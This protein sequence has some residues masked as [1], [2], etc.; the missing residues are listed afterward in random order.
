MPAG[1]PAPPGHSTLR[2]RLLIGGLVLAAPVVAAEPDRTQAAA[3][4]PPAFVRRMLPDAALAGEGRLRFFGLR[5]YDARLWV[6]RRFDADDFGA[7]PLALEL[8]Y[9]RSFAGVDIAKRSIEE[10]E[11]QGGLMPGQALR[12][13]KELAGV[14]PDVQ[15]GDRLTGLYLPGRGMSVWRGPQL[16]GSIDD[17]ELA[18]RFFGIWLSPRTSEPDLRGALLSH[19][20]Q[21]RP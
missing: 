20:A 6:G 13:R 8:T 17:A 3:G 9:H 10:I 2:R 14:L 4:D 5:I 1:R 15:P 11:Q 7:Y 12:W 16:L 18:R 21:A 19:L